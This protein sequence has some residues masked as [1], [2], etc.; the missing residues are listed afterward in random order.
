ME[1]KPVV[2]VTGWSDPS[3]FWSMPSPAISVAPG[4]MLALVSSQ[5]VLSDT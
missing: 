2:V 3:Q 1:I 5:S 4:C